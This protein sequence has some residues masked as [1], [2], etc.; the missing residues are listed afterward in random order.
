VQQ[1]L[2]AVRERRR[3][4]IEMCQRRQRPGTGS[5]LESLMT[6][7]PTMSWPDLTA[8]LEG[9]PWG[10]IGAVAARH[11]MP[12]RMTADIDIAVR[13]EDG[14]EA[15]R[16]L[17]AAGYRRL[18]GLT[19][20]GASWE[21]P[22]GHRVDVVEGREQWWSEALVQA[23]DNQDAQGLPIVPLPYLVL[24]KLR[25]GRVQD[26]ADVT[27]MLGLAEDS[28]LDQVRRL[29]A[30]ESP[31]DLDDLESLITLGQLETRPPSGEKGAGV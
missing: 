29:I 22:T 8:V 31:R 10:V 2:D 28:A 23:A 11:Y 4:I 14:P 26:V 25:T 18:G 27:R 19:T 20:G 17:A 13:A 5:V 6:R 16:R 21:A 9:L 1:R 3:L 7:S 24:T 15:E 12:E 30:D